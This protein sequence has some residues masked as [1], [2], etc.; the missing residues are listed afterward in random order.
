M[1]S[2]AGRHLAFLGEGGFVEHQ[3]GSMAEMLIRILDQKTANIGA[4][5]GG[6]AQH[7]MQ[8]L[9]VA[10]RDLFGHLL[11]IAPVALEKT[12]EIETG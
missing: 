7:V 10:P 11:H 1:S 3:S 12:V 5:P 4:R 6:F 9:I 8:A 2:D